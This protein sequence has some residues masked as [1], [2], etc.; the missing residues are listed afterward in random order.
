M[1]CG[2]LNEKSPGYLNPWFAVGQA[3]WEVW[4]GGGSLSLEVGF[5]S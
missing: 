1:D 3:V 5:E 2:G 4:L